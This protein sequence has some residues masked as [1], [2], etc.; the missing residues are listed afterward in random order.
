[1]KNYTA[2]QISTAG[3]IAAIYTAV[4][5]ATAGI[6]YGPVQF[7]IA[8]SMTLLPLLM[9]EAI[10]GLFVGCFLA[11]IIGG[12]GIA[13]AVIGS[14]A[15]LAAALVTRR[16]KGPLTGGLP[17]VIFNGIAIGAMLKV[18][19]ETTLALPVIMVMI[20]AEEA[21]SVYLFG[22]LLLT[23]IKRLP[24]NISE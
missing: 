22:M 21:V 23:A 3:L 7:R 13:D 6:S 17:P 10:P 9:P 11:N 5:L 16:C 20:A 8:E 19:G 15:T 1:M 2:K 4:T 12:Y 14:L 24:K 18:I